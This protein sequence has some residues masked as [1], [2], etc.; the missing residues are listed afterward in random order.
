MTDA[1]VKATC[2]AAGYLTPCPGPF[3]PIMCPLVENCVQTGLAQCLSPM[4]DVSLALC[5]TSPQDCPPFD[6]VFAYMFGDIGDNNACGVDGATYCDFSQLYHDRYA[7]CALQD[8]SC[9][10]DPCVSLATCADN[11]APPATCTC[12]T[13]YSG[14]GHKTGNGCTDTD[15]CL[16]N[17]CDAQATCVDKPPPAEDATC[18]CNTGYTGDGRATGTGCS[19]VQCV[20]Q[21]APTNGGVSGGNSYGDEVTFTCDT[22]YNLAGSATTTCK[23]DATWTNNPP[24]CTAVQCDVLTAPTNGGVSGGNSYGDEVT[25]TCDT[26]YNLGGSATTTCQADTTWSNSPP[27]CTAV[28]CSPRTA[29]TNGGVSGGSSFG[30]EVTFTCD[31]G[32]DLAGSATTT[33]QA[34]GTWSS[35]D[36]TCTAAQCSPLP[37]PANG[38]VSGSISFGDELTFAYD[39]GYNLAG[40]A[41]T[42]C[43]ADTTWNNSPPTPVQC[44]AQTAPTNGGVSGGNSF[45]DEVT[46]TCDTGYNLGG[47]STTT[48]QAD[49]TWSNSPPTCTAVQCSPRTAPTNGGVSGGSSFGDEVTFT[50]NSGYDLT[51]SATTTCQAGG[52]WSNSDPTCTAG[53]CSPRTAPTNGGVS[54]GSSF[55]DEVTFTCDT[56]YELVGSATTT[57]QAGGTWSNSDPTCTENQEDRL[58]HQ[59]GWKKHESVD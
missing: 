26:G 52:T 12:P 36:P 34:G 38:G 1:N 7:F 58:E 4:R 13:G 57:C 37:A 24:T 19:A 14:D 28:Q 41:I 59:N 18:T 49:T 50:C 32:Y 8:D 16:A 3:D 27:T 11:P 25:F 44:N 29:P 39:T 55:G 35:S 46:F 43:Q 2:V 54:G 42:T 33:C 5:G 17:P 40:S 10:Y 9:L 30:D 48:C 21:T 53:Q 47:S 22:G 20:A 56:G 51:G 31:S 6:G 15:A 45:G 23:A